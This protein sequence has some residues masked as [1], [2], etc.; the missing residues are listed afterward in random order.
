MKVLHLFWC[1]FHF[2]R[3]YARQNGDILFPAESFH[4]TIRPALEFGIEATAQHGSVNVDPK[5]LHADSLRLGRRLTIWRS[6]ASGARITLRRT[7]TQTPLVG[8]QRRVAM[9]VLVYEY[10]RPYRHLIAIFDVE[11][12][13]NEEQLLLSEKFI[14]I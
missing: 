1:F 3:C 4:Q 5:F 11:R 2:G 8:L 12:H 10:N 9:P 6:A 13:A 7:Q 14:D